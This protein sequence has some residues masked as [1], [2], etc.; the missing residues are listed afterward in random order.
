MCFI[1]Y[2][3]VCTSFVSH[4][5]AALTW[6]TLLGVTVLVSDCI[7]RQHHFYNLTSQPTRGRSVAFTWTPWVSLRPNSLVICSPQ[8]IPSTY[9][10]HWGIL[11]TSI[12]GF[13]FFFFQAFTH[14]IIPFHCLYKSQW[15][16]SFALI[17]V[18]HFTWLT[19]INLFWLICSH[20]HGRPPHFIMLH[21]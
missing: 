2:F 13:L 18:L 15:N 10:Y 1:V 21:V 7:E 14:D 8:K 4:N 19:G 3:L 5:A 17:N 11:F 20:L 16:F 9:S 6:T 12:T